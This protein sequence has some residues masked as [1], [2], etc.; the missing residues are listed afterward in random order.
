M[1][2]IKGF[3]DS[4]TVCIRI[5]ADCGTPIFQVVTKFY[6]GYN[7]YIY[8]YFGYYF[9]TLLSPF[10]FIISPVCLFVCSK[11]SILDNINTI[12][13]DALPEYSSLIYCLVISPNFSR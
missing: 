11:I 7:A 10:F 5:V 9:Y 3:L 8:Y 1:N 4:L 13:E 12:Q 2:K 6:A